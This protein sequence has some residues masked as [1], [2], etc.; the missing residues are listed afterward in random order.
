MNN[1]YKQFYALACI[2]LLS[3][4]TLFAQQNVTGKVTDASGVLPGVTITVLG[5]NKSTQTDADGRYSISVASNEKIRFSMI[6]YISQEV[7]PSG[8]T[9]NITLLADA[10]A[11]DE[12]VVTGLGESRER[13]QL[14]Y[15]M[16]QL[17]G[18]EIR[19]TNA[20]NPVA[21]LQGMVPGLQINVGT[22]GP[23]A[24]TR[25]QIRGAGS[26]NQFGNQPLIVVDGIIMDEEV[27]LPNRGG[28][29]D[30]G[31]ILKNINPDDIESISVLNGGSVTALY[32]SRASGGVIMITTKKGYSQR[33]FG[34]GFTHTQGIDQPYA[35]ADMQSKYGPGTSRTGVFVK[36]EDGIERMPT[37]S[38]NAF[39]YS[40]GPELD[41]RTVRDNNGRL[42]PFSANNTPLD[43]YQDGRYVNSNLSLQGGNENTT[44]RLSY[45]NASAKGVSPNNKFGRN[46]F[47]LRATHRMGKA[48]IL[49][50][51]ATYVNSQSHNPQFGGERWN[52]NNNLLYSLSYSLPRY[53]D[54]KHWMDNYLDPINGGYNTADVSGRA[55]TLFALYENKQVQ[56]EDNF[57]GTFNG[58]VNFTDWL[59]LENNFTANLFTTNRQVMNR[60]NQAQFHGGYYANS[61]NRVLQTRYRSNLNANKKYEDFEVM[62]QAGFELNHAQR[63]GISTSTNG[64]VV[65]DVFRIS[66]SRDRA[67]VQEEKP[68]TSRIVS[69]FFQGAMTYRNYLTLNI[70]GRNDWDSSLVYP[71]GSGNYSY[72]YPGADMAFVFTDAFKL[73]ENLFSFG[74]LRVSYNEVGKGT[75][76]YS[77]MTGYYTPNTPYAVGGTSTLPNYGFDSKT[78]GNSNLIPERSDTWE[79]GTE[80]KMLRNRLGLDFTFYQKNTVNQIIPFTVTRESG[81]TA[82][83]VNGGHIRNSGIEMRL[84]GT[85]V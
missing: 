10:S 74:K 53:Y 8:A 58:R 7:V 40:F 80:I 29:Q 3:I 77:A 12:V 23:Q 67:N 52:M 14:G 78:L 4:S 21:A 42:I 38:E 9:I 22:G 34:I 17:S 6:G 31:N 46:N 13:R 35:T 57:R 56:I 20:I 41:G 81:V 82:R 62:L 44:F 39:F 64:L 68:N 50:V 15:S 47:N 33:G 76:V 65:P 5:T 66:N 79:L 2:M 43:I 49:D 55:A 75:S 72:F 11:I 18:D 71:D 85:P 69:G 27:V 48:I 25:F 84:Y 63:N 51:G 1:S 45:S 70:Y 73:P 32:G 24:S 61:T 60:G 30:F 28:D 16:T 37:T 83:L 26:L 19:K 36:G 54:L 59:Q